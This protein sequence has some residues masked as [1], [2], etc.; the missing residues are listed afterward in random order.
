MP[1]SSNTAA[2]SEKVKTEFRRRPSHSLDTRQRHLQTLADEAA[3]EKKKKAEKRE[4]DTQKR[5]ER[6]RKRS[7]LRDSQSGS[8]PEGSLSKPPTKPKTK[9][10]PVAVKPTVSKLRHTQSY[11]NLNIT[12]T[13]P[14]KSELGIATDTP[15]QSPTVTEDEVFDLS[16]FT[17]DFKSSQD[18]VSSAVDTILEVSN[19]EQN[20]SSETEQSETNSNTEQNTSADSKYTEAA[21]QSQISTDISQTTEQPS[22]GSV[23]PPTL[24]TD[25]EEQLKLQRQAQEKQEQEKQVDITT[26]LINTNNKTKTE[27]RDLDKQLKQLLG[28]AAT[29]T[30]TQLLLNQP[31]TLQELQQQEQELLKAFKTQEAKV[32]QVKL[33]RLQK[34]R[35]EQEEIDGLLDNNNHYKQHIRQ[36]NLQLRVL[37]GPTAQQAD[38]TLLTTQPDTKEEL[39]E[40]AVEL[41]AVIRKYQAILDNLQTEQDN[42]KLQQ[43]QR[44]RSKRTR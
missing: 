29:L 25:A 20:I 23:E 10:P 33:D 6:A 35:E 31:T 44:R 14:T 15:P 39:E 36:I 13:P 38:E 22:E 41:S 11:S 18:N 8:T 21:E 34:Q 37:D 5:T 32:T 2:Q 30:D 19:I 28:N 7:L 3:A 16:K 12:D 1:L 42:A 4:L 26:K 9:Q 43:Q 17:E 27:L 24:S 40:Q